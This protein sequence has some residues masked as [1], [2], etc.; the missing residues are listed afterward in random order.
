MAA[1]A[2]GLDCALEAVEDCCAG[3]A[4][5][6]RF[7]VASGLET[8]PDG[9]V[10]E[11]YG[12]PHT[13]YQEVVYLQV[14]V[15]RRLRLHRRIGLRE[16]TGYGVQ[17][18]THA[19][20]LAMHFERGQDYQRAVQYLQQAGDRALMRSACREAM[21][22]FEQALSALSQLPETRETREQ[23]IDLWL[24]LRT[25]L[26]PLGDLERV[27]TCLRTAEALAVTLDDPR[28]LARISLL[29]S[30]YY[31]LMGLYNQASTAAQRALTFTTASGDTVLQALA[32][33]NLG[34]AYH[35]QGDYRRAGACLR[36]TV[37]ALDGARG[38]EHFGQTILPAVNACAHLA[39]CHAEVGT[40]AEGCAL[41]NAGLQIAEAVGHPGSL[42][43][44]LWGVGLIALHQ[45]DL[46]R[47]LSQL[48][49]AMRLCEEADLRGTSTQ[50]R[51][52]TSTPPPGGRTGPGSPD[53]AHHTGD[54]GRSPAPGRPPPDSCLSWVTARTRCTPATVR[55]ACRPR[56][57]SNQGRCCSSHHARYLAICS[58]S[59]KS[60]HC[61]CTSG[62]AAG[63]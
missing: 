36:Q 38:R 62:G 60:F 21:A 22:Y 13:L 28:R 29:L 33:L 14:P 31:S 6:G 56:R 54:T 17:A 63:R 39:W 16:E 12:W 47:A 23:T 37:M 10:T 34:L 55:S 15:G 2:A 52:S 57:S 27:L 30:R 59:G 9:T 45:G 18:S 51:A 35:A 3:L 19:A 50:G 7:L 8:W 32:N 48:E 24:A 40:F 61:R 44:A 25:A 41:G 26:Q 49:R 43:V 42:M 20:E 11:R 46:R 1:V 5:Q 58:V 4:Q 53:P